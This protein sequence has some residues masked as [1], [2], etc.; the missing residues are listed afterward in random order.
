MTLA[1]G[2]SMKKLLFI[3]CAEPEGEAVTRP[4]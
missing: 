4:A 3:G 1:G 2:P